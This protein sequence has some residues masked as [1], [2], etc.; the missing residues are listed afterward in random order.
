M[1]LPVALQGQRIL[2]DID[3][4]NVLDGAASLAV[5]ALNLV[6]SDNSVLEGTA[7][8]DEEDGIRVTT[9][10]LASAGD[11]TTVGLEATIKGALDN[12]GGLV[13]DRALGG[14]DR[15][16]GALGKAGEASGRRGSGASS[17]GSGKGSDGGD[18]GELHF[19][20][21]RWMEI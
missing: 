1:I 8:L 21:C 15:D 13:G 2:A 6:L 14:R 3:P 11:T 12:H 7:V 4:P 9:L 16:G 20:G 10:G 5:D 19:G 18:D 17:D